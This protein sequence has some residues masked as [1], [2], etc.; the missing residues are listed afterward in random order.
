MNEQRRSAR[1]APWG[2]SARARLRPP[3]LTV[4]QGERTP[5]VWRL[6]ARTV[7]AY[8]AWSLWLRALGPPGRRSVEFSTVVLDRERAAAAALCD[9][10]RA[11]GACPS[12]VADVDPRYVDA[13]VSPTRTGASARITASIRSRLARAAHGSSLTQRPHRVGRLDPHHAGRAPARAAHRAH[14]CRQ[15]AP[16]GAGD[17]SSSARSARTRSSR[18]TSASRPTAAI[19][20]A[21]APPRSPISARSRAG[22]RSA[23]RR[24][25]WRCRSRRRRAGRIARPT[26][27][28]RARDR[29]L[30]RAGG[31]RPRAG[32]RDR[33]GQGRAGAGRAPA[34]AD[35][36]AA[37]R[38]SGGRAAPER[39]ESSPHH[40]RPICRRSLEEL[41]RERARSARPRNLGR[42]RRRSTT[43]PA[44]CWPASPRR[45]ISTQRAPARST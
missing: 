3:A 43:R 41:A 26:Q 42:H 5:P 8:V 21:C 15:A 35:A 4:P 12:T 28:A 40:R 22:F 30:D 2:R 9:A 24:C 11:A 16:D 33:P 6:V 32:R 39:R 45:T 36:R 25:W 20:K 13:A 17:R 29:V 34:D 1:L 7:A 23:K 18:S 27:R 37:R 19:S 38:R 31:E 44:R 10:R 14:T